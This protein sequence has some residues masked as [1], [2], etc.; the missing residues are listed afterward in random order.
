VRLLSA[1]RENRSWWLI[2]LRT[3]AIG[4]QPCVLENLSARHLYRF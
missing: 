3:R 2:L 1:E 4:I